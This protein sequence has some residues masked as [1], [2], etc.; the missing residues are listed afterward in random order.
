VTAPDFR[1]G[2]LRIPLAVWLAVYC[3]ALLTRRQL[4]LVSVVIRETWGWQTRGGDV[5]LWT[6]PLTPRQ[7]GELTGLSTDHLAR[8]LRDLVARGIVRVDGERYQFV[9]DPRLWITPPPPAPEQRPMAPEWWADGAESALGTPGVKTGKIKDRNVP[10]VTRSDLSPTGDNFRASRPDVR[11]ADAE[12]PG[13]DRAPT[14]PSPERLADVITA[15]VGTL[16]PADAE[17]LRAW[18]CEAGNAGVWSALEPAFREGPAA[19]RRALASRLASRPQPDALPSKSE[20]E[21][22]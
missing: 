21:G 11:F 10:H 20:R 7:F 15:F 3:R 5:R 19:G 18:I 17:A 2:Y 13:S 16:A 4:Q 12:W 22:E 14:P 1:R 9:P 8:D 6:R